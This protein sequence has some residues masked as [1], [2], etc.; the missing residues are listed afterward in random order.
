M[1]ER[2]SGWA[3]PAGRG[4]R[5]DQAGGGVLQQ[6]A[7]RRRG[8]REATVLNRGCILPGLH[9]RVLLDN[10]FQIFKRKRGKNFQ[11]TTY[12]YTYSHLNN[13]HSYFFKQSY[14]LILKLQF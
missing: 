8:Q 13:L 10:P 9:K 1:S 7:G 12:T 3:S 2:G 4:W 5:E 14:V 11:N 6:D